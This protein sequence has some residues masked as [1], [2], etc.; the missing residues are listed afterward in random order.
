MSNFTYETED[1]KTRFERYEW[2]NT[3]IENTD[4]AESSRVFYIGDSISC[5][6]RTTGTYLTKG[7]ILFDGFGTSKGLDNPFFKDG[8]S[9]FAA[10]LPCIERILF[11]NGLHGFHLNDEEEY[12]KYYEEMVKFLL[13]KFPNVPLYIVLTTCVANE[14]RLERVKARN[15][16]ALEMADKYNLSVIDLYTV[17]EQK[18]DLLRPDGVHFTQE[19]YDALAGEIIS[20]VRAEKAN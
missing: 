6:T 13:E 7:E 3:W 20:V 10:Q 16:A 5:K 18:K 9:L 15:K 19:G 11:N 4:N 12:G 1:R 14:A 17:S 2:D 8:I